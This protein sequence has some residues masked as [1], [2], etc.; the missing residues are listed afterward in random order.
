MIYRHKENGNE[1]PNLLFNF[2]N[3]L[4]GYFFSLSIKFNH[5]EGIC[6]KE[7]VS[8]NYR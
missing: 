6:E 2:F 3:L 5:D 8:K 4:S 7:F 1:V